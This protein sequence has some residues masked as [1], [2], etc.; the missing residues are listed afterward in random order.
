MDAVTAKSRAETGDVIRMSGVRFTW[1]GRDAF[2]LAVDA[3]S[4]PAAKRILL[5]GPSGSGKSTF[6]SLICGIVAPQAGEIDIL[7]TDITK[8]PASAR[9]GFRAEHFGIIFQI[10]NLL[11]YGT[12]IDNVLL[13]LSFAPKRR[14]RATARGKAEDEAVRLLTRLGL[15]PHLTR[16]PSAAN[17]SVGQQQRVAA[18]RALI[19]SPKIIVADEPTS[20]LDRNRQAAFLELL[21]TQ[22]SEAGATLIMVSHD[23]TLAGRFDEVMRLEA[24]AI[25]GQRGP[26]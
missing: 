7:G 14:E 10:F 19:G 11:P 12:V 1:P 23:E 17:L 21:F 15:E 25:S 3:F 13:P 5:I 24:I 18:A 26:T 4:L 9:D 6:L 22:V 16:G 8:L 2:S 20:A